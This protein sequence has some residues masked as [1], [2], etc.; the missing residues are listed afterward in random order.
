[1][2]SSPEYTIGELAH[3]FGLPTN[4]LRHWESVGLLTPPRTAGGRRR[5]GEPDAVRIALILQ[6]K[7]LG[8]GLPQIRRV[9][10]TDDPADR[11]TALREH[12]E[13]L[14]CRIAEAQ[15]A[16]ELIGHALECTSEDFLYCPHFRDRLAD[17]VP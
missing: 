14:T 3:R 10:D 15:A 1:M 4:V 9:L 8:F 2:K 13:Q 6:G 11:R 12:H 17:L 7:R 16:R 5:Y